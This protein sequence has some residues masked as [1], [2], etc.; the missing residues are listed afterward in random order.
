[1]EKH[2]HQ[3][4]RI[5]LGKDKR[6]HMKCA[7]RGC[8]HNLRPEL[9]VGRFSICNRCFNEFV[10]TKANMQL[11]KPHCDECTDSKKVKT[12]NTLANILEEMEN[13]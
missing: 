8:P 13:K 4:I 11:A 5:K 2:T 10:L 1:M 12:V 9:A 3:Y 7:V 6:A